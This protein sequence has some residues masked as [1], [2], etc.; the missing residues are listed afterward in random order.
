MLELIIVAVIAFVVGYTVSQTLHL[1]TLR[2]IL[3]DLGITNQQLIDLAR[4]K[5]VDVDHIVDPDQD[6]DRPEVEIRVESVNDQLLA[7]DGQ[8]TFVAQGPDADQLLSRIVEHF[9]TG[10]R[11]RIMRGDH[12]EAMTQ[13]LLRS[14]R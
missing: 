9:P 6:A 3:K 13:A 1:M 5:G 8:D 2:T 14:Q 11:V 4:S 10:T 7:Y 12:T